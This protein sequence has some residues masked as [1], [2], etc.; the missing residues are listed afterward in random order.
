MSTAGERIRARRQALGLTQDQLA[1]RAGM[2]KGF[3]SDVET[4]TR[5]LSAGKLLKLSQAL[6]TSLDYLMKGKGS[7]DP[8]DT[9]KQV[10]FPVALVRLA[11]ER[12]LGF[13]IALTLLEMRLQVVAHRNDSKDDG[14]LD[15]FDWSG[16]YDS[17]KDYL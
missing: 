4:G 8:E 7:S 11:K 15:V 17:V 16:F 13:D 14:D 2:S 9:A 10:S 5:N 3:L 1:Q 12:N 6:G